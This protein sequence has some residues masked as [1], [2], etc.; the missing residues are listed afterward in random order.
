MESV[1]QL[2][3]AKKERLQQTDQK[4]QSYNI[5]EDRAR[6]LLNAMELPKKVP[7][8]HEENKYRLEE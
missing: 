1:K 8:N 2:L 3:L 5:V 6:K 4:W 7:E